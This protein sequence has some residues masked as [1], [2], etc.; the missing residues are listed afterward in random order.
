MAKNTPYYPTTKDV[1]KYGSTGKIWKTDRQTDRQADRQI[2]R[3]IDRQID[4]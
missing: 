4:K 2:D 3:L 1:K